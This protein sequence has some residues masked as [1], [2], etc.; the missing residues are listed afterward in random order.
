MAKTSK[1]AKNEQR[2][3]IV[4]KYADKRQALKAI[5]Q[6]SKSSHEDVQ[7][8]QHLLRKLPRDANPNRIRN[9][10]GLTG[11]PRGYYRKFNLS[12]IAMRELALRGDLPGVTKASW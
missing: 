1:I 2:K 7:E 9:R 3:K 5:I 6:D 8:A 4:A 11:R 10:C 12:R